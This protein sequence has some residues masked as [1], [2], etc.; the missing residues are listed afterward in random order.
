MLLGLVGRGAHHAALGRVAVT[1]HHHGP[2]A[3]FGM[4]EDL[5]RRDE[6]VE[7]H[8]QHPARHAPLLPRPAGSANDPRL[9]IRLAMQDF[10]DREGFSTAWGLLQFPAAGRRAAPSAPMPGFGPGACFAGEVLCRFWCCFGVLLLFAACCGPA[11]ERGRAG[12]C[13]FS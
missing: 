12:G 5:D 11:A 4:P 9:R 8:V 2:P 10:D 3:Q 6:L 7:V 1:A 13:C